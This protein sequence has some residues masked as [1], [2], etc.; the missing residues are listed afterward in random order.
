MGEH[1]L[2]H[3]GKLRAWLK[4]GYLERGMFHP[5]AEGTPQGGIISPTAANIALDG[6]AERL[7]THFKGRYKVN[8]V[9]YADDFIIT[10]VSQTLLEEEVKPLV[11]QFL[12]ER[13]LELAEEKTRIVRID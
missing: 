5:T 4:A 8:L 7:K 9:R 10:G 2:T 13:G 11:V 1:V 12:T 6:L 3:Q